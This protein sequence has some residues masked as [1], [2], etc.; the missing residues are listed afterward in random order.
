M[1]VLWAFPQQMMF[2]LNCNLW[3]R[4][5]AT[6]VPLTKLSTPTP[7][8][9]WGGDRN[10]PLW[11][12]DSH[13][14]LCRGQWNELQL[15]KMVLSLPTPAPVQLFSVSSIG[16]PSSRTACGV[17]ASESCKWGCHILW[18][19]MLYC[20]ENYF[21]N[22][23]QRV[24]SLLTSDFQTHY[25]SFS[26][27]DPADAEGSWDMCRGDPV[28]LSLRN[29]G[30]F[31]SKGVSLSWE[32]V[33]PRA[34][35]CGAAAN[36]TFPCMYFSPDFPQGKGESGYARTACRTE[37]AHLSS[38]VAVRWSHLALSLLST[39]IYSA[40]VRQRPIGQIPL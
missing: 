15:S 27:R 40:L 34:C 4:S 37:I 8:K 22:C 35:Q 6:S 9:L 23:K 28:C 13:Q 14:F 32:A 5:P 18:L 39:S 12:S 16:K 10:H 26:H 3:V 36:S 2:A 20:I 25:F 29:A 11:R 21:K 19:R 31:A 24:G 7:G 38:S 30:T 1:D 33:V 17:T